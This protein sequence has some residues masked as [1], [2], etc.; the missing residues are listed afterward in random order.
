MQ[1]SLA[2]SGTWIAYT[3]QT[4]TPYHRE[5]WRMNTDGA[6]LKQL[7]FLGDDPDY[8][9][10]NAPNISPDEQT[11]AFFSGK[12]SDRAVPGA[13]QQPVFTFG[14][15]N[16]AIVPATGGARK[17]LTPCQ[18]VTTQAELD[19]ATEASGN[20]IA[21]DNPAWTPDSKWLIFDTGFSTG[22]GTWMV[23]VNGQNYQRFYSQ[24]RGIVRVPLK[25]VN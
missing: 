25:F 14:H 17:T 24:G 19:A 10:A 4:D 11:V 18:P 9:D 1:P 7:T 5:I 16:V 23:D 20:C 22:G 8:P 21:A 13:P 12:E 6:G 2:L 3:L 15:R